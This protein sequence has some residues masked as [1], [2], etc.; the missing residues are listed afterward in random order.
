MHSSPQWGP[1]TLED[2]EAELSSLEFDLG[3]PPELGSDVE[4]FFQEPDA[5]QG[6]GK[7]SDPFPEPLVENYKKWIK[8]RSIC[9]CVPNWWKELI[10]ILGI[11]DF[12]KLAQ[13]I[14]ASFEIPQVRSK[15]QGGE[16]DYSAPPASTCICQ[17]DFLPPP[18]PGFS[19]WNTQDG[20]ALKTL[21]YAQALQ[22]WAEKAS[23]PMPGQPHLLVACVWEL[24]WTMEE[25]VALTED[26]ILE[27]AVP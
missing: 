19:C 17:K 27:G 8:W 21:A 13:K 6:E 11:D 9:I 16:N 14:R 26:A 23:L 7:T 20:Q 24:K 12:Q 22:Y 2:Q 4:C 5:L 15:A 25:Y 10:G 3:P 18:D 1:E